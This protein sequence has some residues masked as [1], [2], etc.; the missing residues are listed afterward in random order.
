[1]KKIFNLILIFFLLFFILTILSTI[2]LETNKF[3]KIVSK[4]IKENKA[5]IL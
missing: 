2:G 3:N 1:M 5:N 4:R